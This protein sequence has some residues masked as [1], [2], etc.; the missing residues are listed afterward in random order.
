MLPI[1][2]AFPRVSPAEVLPVV[3]HSQ[4]RDTAKLQIHAEMCPSTT[5]ASQPGACLCIYPPKF[6]VLRGQT[7]STEPG[8]A[9]STGTVQL[10]QLTSAGR[11]CTSNGFTSTQETGWEGMSEPSPP[12][13]A[14]ADLDH[15]VSFA[16]FKNFLFWRY[17]HFPYNSSLAFCGAIE[18]S[19][20]STS[21]TG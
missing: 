7:P 14:P 2:A 16:S 12:N 15:L 3:G 11:P 13:A 4:H 21:K 9:V 8:S 1:P 17:Q 20:L 6:G 10:H 5:S 19:F 18:F